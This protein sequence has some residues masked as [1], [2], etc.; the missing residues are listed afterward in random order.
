M[1]TLRFKN[2]TNLFCTATFSVLTDFYLSSSSEVT[3]LWR[4]T[5][6]FII[7]IIS[8]VLAMALCL[9]PSFT[10]HFS[11]M[12]GLDCIKGASVKVIVDDKGIRLMEGVHGETDE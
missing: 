2:C 7:I 9:S 1:N 4:Y 3:T 5:N 8:M 12:S 10:C 6:Q 11:T